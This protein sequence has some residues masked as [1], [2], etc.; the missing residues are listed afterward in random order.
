ML[1]RAEATSFSVLFG[2]RNLQFAQVQDAE[3]KEQQGQRKGRPERGWAEHS[4]EHGFNQF[5]HGQREDEGLEDGAG[6]GHQAKRLGEGR[7][8]QAMAKVGAGTNKLQKASVK[9]AM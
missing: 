8:G 5:A 7:F 9:I 1:N 3:D 6:G 4:V 2:A